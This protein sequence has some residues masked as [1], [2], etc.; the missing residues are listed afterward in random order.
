MV[1]I[2]ITSWNDTEQC[3]FMIVLKREFM[4]RNNFLNLWC[5]ILLGRLMLSRVFLDKTV[6]DCNAGMV[7]KYRF[8]YRMWVAFLWPLASRWCQCAPRHGKAPWLHGISGKHYAEMLI[9]CFVIVVNLH[10]DLCSYSRHDLHNFTSQPLW[11]V[12]WDPA[13][14]WARREPF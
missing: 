9:L 12:G 3:E 4:H 6:F 7:S 5:D 14:I 13:L 11:K 10:V 2:D 1:R 8:G